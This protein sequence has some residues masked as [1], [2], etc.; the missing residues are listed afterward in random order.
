MT[1]NCVLCNASVSGRAIALSNPDARLDRIRAYAT[2]IACGNRLADPIALSA[3][4]HFCAH[5]NRR[6]RF[7]CAALR[8][9]DIRIA[10]RICG[11]TALP[12]RID[13]VGTPHSFSPS[14]LICSLDGGALGITNPRSRV[15]HLSAL[16]I[17]AVSLSAFTLSGICRV[18]VRLPDNVHLLSGVS[19]VAIDFS[20][21]HL[22][23]GAVG[24]PTDYIRIVGL[25]SA[26]ALAIR[27]RQLV[28]IALYNPTNSLRTLGPRRIIVRVSTS[29]FCITVNRRGVTY[30][31][32]IPTG[33]GVFTLNDCIIRYGVR[34]G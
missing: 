23:A 12:I 28:G 29:S 25:P 18:P 30:H 7:R 32:C 9:S 3:N 17:N 21:S 19:D 13:F 26:C 24:L 10:L 11:L 6:I 15:S 33:S 22:R 14:I 4:L 31:L 34:D 5:D 1:S 27:A 20:D 8:A 2:R 16:S